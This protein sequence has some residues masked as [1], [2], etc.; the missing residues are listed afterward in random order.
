MPMQIKQSLHLLQE[1]ASLQ[2]AECQIL[3]EMNLV[4]CRSLGYG[5]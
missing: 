2:S 4:F 5:I 3:E 1:S